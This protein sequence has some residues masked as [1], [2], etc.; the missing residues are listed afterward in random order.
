MQVEN[1]E[2]AC[3]REFYSTEAGRLVKAHADNHPTMETLVKRSARACGLDRLA[4]LKA[5][6]PM[7]TVRR[8]FQ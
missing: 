6:E 7:E 1:A 3:K 2:A 8:P 5:K 4:G